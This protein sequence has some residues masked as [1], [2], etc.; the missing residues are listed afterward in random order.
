MRDIE[1]T[2]N[3]KKDFSRIR[4]KDKDVELAA[5]VAHALKRFKK[6]ANIIFLE[7]G[8]R[9]AT[10]SILSTLINWIG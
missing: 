7:S 5:E 10:Y 6:G 4:D 2:K 3:A 1:L 8:K 9:K